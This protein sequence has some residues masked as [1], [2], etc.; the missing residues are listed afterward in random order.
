[1]NDCMALVNE[2]ADLTVVA[3]RYKLLMEKLDFLAGYSPAELAGYGITTPTPFQ[4]Q[5]QTIEA[6]KATVFNQAIDRAYEKERQH[7]DSLKTER[8]KE[9][10]LSR[11]YDNTARIIGESGIPSEC[12]SHLESVYQSAAAQ[13]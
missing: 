6:N 11:F 7:I 13:I 3:S 10:A 8:G 4:Q 1:M 5:K 12:L 2:S 9:N